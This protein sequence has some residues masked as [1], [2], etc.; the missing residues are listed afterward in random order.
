MKAILCTIPKDDLS[1][2][3]L[4]EV[5]VPVP[6]AGEV[7]VKV[8]AASL[9]P[10][11][12]KLCAG[13]APWWSEPHVVGLDAAGTIDAIGEGVT[14]WMIGDRVVWHGNLN[15][16]GVFADYA[17]TVAHVLTRVPEAVPFEAAAA[18][19]CAGLTAF[20]ALV[21]KIRLSAD[22]TIVIQGASG[23]VGGFAVQIARRIGARVIA[24]ARPEKA[25]RVVALGADV[26]LDYR[27]PDLALK[28]RAAND[29]F[30]ADAMLE[31][32]N[33]RD[34]RKSL[35]LLR[36]NGH[37][38]CIDPLAD[39]SQTPPYTYAASIHEVALGGAYGAGDLRTQ[40]DFA[41]MGEVLVGWLADGTLDP[42]IEHRIGLSE[43][44]E[45]LARLRRREFDGKA[46]VRIS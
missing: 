2:T 9:N 1:T 18:I 33:P 31:V 38:A 26:V 24:L 43:V 35:S 25:E 46:V 17:T 21:R 3:S 5:Q 6:A 27:D 10:V 23:G 29:G 12:W 34:A 15:R 16:Q 28:V 22:Q 11:D 45:Y 13:V 37:L 44:P 7:R 4:A 20:Q 40:R 39:L 32:S 19:P 42:M 41:A 36:Y 30:G 14:G 8:A